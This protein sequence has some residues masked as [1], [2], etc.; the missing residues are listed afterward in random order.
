[1]LM[2]TQM[3]TLKLNKIIKMVHLQGEEIHLVT[4]DIM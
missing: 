3:K 4:L 2:K 1:M